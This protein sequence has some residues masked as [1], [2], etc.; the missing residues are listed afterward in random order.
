[1]ESHPNESD[2]KVAH[3]IEFFSGRW[4]LQIVFWLLQGP[5]RFN[6]LQRQLGPIT[7]RTLSRQLTEMMDA[8]LV[9]RNDFKTVP[10]HVEYS[11]TPMGH[12]LVPVLEIIRDW[13]NNNADDL[14]MPS[15]HP[16]P[17]L[18]EPLRL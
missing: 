12:S 6:A 3:V 11:L 5:Y 4:K 13:A 16:S 9:I 17:T 15:K 2:C 10:P 1:M 8:G 7:H 14:R 18:T